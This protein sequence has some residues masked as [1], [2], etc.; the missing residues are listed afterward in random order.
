MM[1]KP[2]IPELVESHKEA[3]ERRLNNHVKTDTGCWEYLGALN[4]FGYG[5]VCLPQGSRHSGFMY[6]LHRLSYYYHT[7]ND[8]GSLL[9]RHDCDNPACINPEHL[10]LGTHKEN[11]K[12]ALDRDRLKRGEKCGWAK[13]TG[14]QVLNIKQRLLSGE[15]QHALASEFGVDQSAI[16]RLGRGR[17]WSHVQ[18]PSESLTKELPNPHQ[19]PLFTI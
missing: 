9:V 17:T 1:K 10:R 4:D 6:R 15:R 19:L 12:D 16:S 2:T 13:L 5:V 8:P 11:T 14:E 18:L 3:V 7:H